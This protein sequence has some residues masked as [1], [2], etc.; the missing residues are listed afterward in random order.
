MDHRPIL[1]LG[2]D[3]AHVAVTGGKG[4]IGRVVVDHFL[5]AGAI[6]SSLDITYSPDGASRSDSASSAFTSI[7][8]DVA[9]EE[10]VQQAFATATKA[11]G[12]VDICIALA[13]LDLSTL[14]PS[15]F[16]TASFSQLQRVLGVNVA[17]TFLTARE[18]VRGLHDAKAT[19]KT[20]KHPNL[21][22]IGSES[23]HF[24]ERRNVDY[25][26]AKSAVQGGLL[27]S[28]R[29][30]VPR[31]WPGARVN[32]VAP[33]PVET[34]RWHEECRINPEQYYREAQATTALG[35]PIPIRAVAMAILS[36]ASH[37]FSSHVHG[38]VINVDGGKQ[39]KL[40]YSRAEAAQVRHAGEPCDA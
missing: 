7:H 8:C 6:V 13:S 30:E 40:I 12:P 4:L 19:G 24:G 14:E 10:S 18:W 35:E 16:A 34:E 37:N 21:I 5:A 17:G 29:A 28:L 31:E 1:D 33:G 9:D 15:A 22:I 26:L 36:L 39:G 3:G 38:Q 11:H 25:S 2:L 20:M 27:M 32:V 23:G